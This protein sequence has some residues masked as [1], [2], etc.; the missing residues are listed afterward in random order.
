MKKI[1]FFIIGLSVMVSTAYAADDPYLEDFESYND[2][3]VYNSEDLVV[4]Y[5]GYE[6]S[7]VT[8]RYIINGRAASIAM[9]KLTPPMQQKIFTVMLRPEMEQQTLCL[10]D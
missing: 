7:N 1:A 9:M 2:F 5:P 10:E 3:A 8:G 4:S 6:N